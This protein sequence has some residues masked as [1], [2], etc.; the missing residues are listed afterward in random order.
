MDG[1]VRRALTNMMEDQLGEAVETQVARMDWEQ[2]S[3]LLD[4]D[5]VA[6]KLTMN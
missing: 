1:K 5:K 6:W 2:R 4:R 3:D